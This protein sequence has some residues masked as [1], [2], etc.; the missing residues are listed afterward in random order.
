MKIKANTVFTLL[1]VIFF[2]PYEYWGE[3]CPVNHTLVKLIRFATGP[4]TACIYLTS[5]S[6][7]ANN[8]FGPSH[9]STMC[10]L[11]HYMIDSEA[12]FNSFR[13]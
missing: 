11:L 3:V 7:T 6:R 12:L 5:N 10:M 4:L 1:I 13:V 9:R 8:L 2:I